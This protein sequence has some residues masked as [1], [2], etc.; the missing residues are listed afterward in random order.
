MMI[1]AGWVSLINTIVI[2]DDEMKDC[3]INC[4]CE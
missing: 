4:Q 2:V 1:D 3:T